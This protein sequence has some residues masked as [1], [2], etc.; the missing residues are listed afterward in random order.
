V[1]CDLRDPTA[2]SFKIK[3]AAH[4]NKSRR[5]KLVT[6]VLSPLLVLNPL[7]SMYS[8]W[9]QLIADLKQQDSVILALA[10]DGMRPPNVLTM[11]EQLYI[12]VK[13][14]TPLGKV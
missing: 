2:I 6:D 7:E 3:E 10:D 8:Y 14:L 11:M 13:S 1:K 9:S 5:V 4:R 12:S